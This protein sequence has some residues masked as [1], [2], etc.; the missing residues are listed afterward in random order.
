MRNILIILGAVAA[1]LV[2]AVGIYQWQT[3]RPGSS[4]A[5]RTEAPRATA[6]EIARA[7]A[8]GDDDFTIGKAD[9]PVTI[10]EYASLTCPHCAAFHNDVLPKIKAAYIDAGKV[11]MAFRDFPLDQAALA[12]AMVARCAGKDR[13]HAMLDLFFR[14]QESWA[15]AAD[16]IGAMAKLAGIAGMSEADVQACLRNE[17]AEKAVLDQRLLSEKVFDVDRTPTFVINGVKHRGDVTF[18]DFRKAIDPLVT[19]SVPTQ[20]QPAR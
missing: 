17:A 8:V 18:E 19:R 20:P 15:G 13:H 2:G 11:R 3:G 5:P 10:I 9:A 6:E 4:P 12:A 7:K 16:P 1:L 14:R